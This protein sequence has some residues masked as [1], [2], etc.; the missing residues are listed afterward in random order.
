[1][2]HY[3]CVTCGTQFAASVEPP[4]NCPICADERQYIGW[5][6]QV[7][8]TLAQLR[9]SHH[10]V[11]S[12]V[13]QHLT[14]IVTEPAFAIGQR[15]LLIHTPAGNCLW[16]CVSFID[17]A[18][19]AAVMALGG[20]AVIAISHPHFYSS[21]ID[22]SRAFGDVPVFLHADDAACVMR[23]DRAIVSWQGDKREILPGVTL[24]RCGGHFSGS[25]VLH[26]A[27]GAEE[28]GALLTGDTITVV[29][30]RRYVSFMR[31]YPNLIPLPAREV[32]RIVTTVE[33]FAYDR[34]YG[35]WPGR[36]ILSDAKGA[37]ARSA[38]RY[39]KA[40]A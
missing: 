18:T 39:L 9:L 16:D 13:D 33:P 30:D 10:N 24:V 17:E 3:I 23:P 40:I 8:T 7:W 22:W 2:P 37:V 19:I 36:D 21:M 1:M 34:I 32:R 5:Y 11:I 6:G 31:S 12:T 29:P 4:P 27:A 20:I 14:S 25:T 15:A 38:E 28:R 35:G 26:W